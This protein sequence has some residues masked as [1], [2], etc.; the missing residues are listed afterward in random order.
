MKRKSEYEKLGVDPA[1]SIVR[2][3]FGKIIDN[4]FPYAFVNI[5]RDQ[6]IPGTVFTKHSD[7]DG[8]KFVQRVL[9]YLETD[10]ESIFQ[11]AVDDALAMNT[12]DIAASGFVFGKWVITE[13]IN[14][15]GF[16][17]P[18]D[19]I[20]E[21]IALRVGRL[22]QL[23]KDR[24]FNIFFLGGETADLPD[25]IGSAVYDMDIYAR[26]KESDL[27]VGNVKPGDKI[28]GFAS[29]GKAVWEEENNSGIM[30]NGL[31]LA[32]TYLMNKDY[33]EMYPF[34]FG[35]GVSYKGKFYIKDNIAVSKEILSPTRQWA[36]AIRMII[37]KLKE[38]NIFHM[39]H[40]ISMNTGG[41][42]AKIMHVGSGILYKKKMPIPPPI[43]QLIQKE[44]GEI[45]ENMYE[46][47][48][49]GVGIDVVGEDNAEFKGVLQEISDKI[50][51]R[52]FEL[53]ECAKNTNGGN[54]IVLETP[55]GFFDNY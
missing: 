55:Y 27:I 29:D 12:G 19:I 30:S 36:I 4:D 40:G 34:L 17:I 47:F 1:K 50:G 48:N 32:R 20:M 23:Y 5:K 37:E 49:C 18:K 8:S 9:H 53:G 39:L 7:G 54:K 6:E 2:E 25:Q 26:A 3:I 14:I 13:I 21:Q 10:D 22:L 42:A 45:W 35:A 52:L 41:G 43:F 15:N 46:D 38:K 31:T 51:I 16:N 28:Y 44:S 33:A 11:G 24:G